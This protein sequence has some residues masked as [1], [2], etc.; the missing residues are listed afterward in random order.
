[1]LNNAPFS[2][3]INS[4]ALLIIFYTKNTLLDTSV[5]PIT[6]QNG[7]TAFI[8]TMFEVQDTLIIINLLAS[9]NFMKLH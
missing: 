2:R 1:M 5:F 3:H 7:V 8:P 6:K 4:N 9:F